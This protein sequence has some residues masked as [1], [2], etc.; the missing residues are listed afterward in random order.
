VLAK[1]RLSL[2]FSSSSSYS[3]GEALGLESYGLRGFRLHPPVRLL[4]AVEGGRGDGK[5]AANLLDGLDLLGGVA[6]AFHGLF[7]VTNSNLVKGL[8]HNHC[9]DQ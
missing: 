4:P 7:E 9:P 3:F 1:S 5:G 8:F 6:A 2:V